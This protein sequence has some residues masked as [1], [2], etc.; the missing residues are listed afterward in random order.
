M[1][2]WAHPKFANPLAHKHTILGT[3]QLAFLPSLRLQ[4]GN[5]IKRFELGDE[6]SVLAF[7]HQSLS[8]LRRG[9]LASRVRKKFVTA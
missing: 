5:T 7:C 6:A 1:I 9:R 8:C 3:F 4:K 2:D